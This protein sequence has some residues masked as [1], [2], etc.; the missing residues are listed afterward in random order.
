MH[1]ACDPRIRVMSLT[2]PRSFG[3][4]QPLP[5]GVISP[6]AGQG[7]AVE[8]RAGQGRGLAQPVLRIVPH[9]FQPIDCRV[10]NIMGMRVTEPIHQAFVVISQH[11]DENQ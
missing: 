3:S 7:R 11:T 2:A 4:T 5:F 6:Q 8:G 10:W 1:C 9:L